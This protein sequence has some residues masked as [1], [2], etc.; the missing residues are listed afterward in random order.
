MSKF[1]WRRFGSLWLT[2]AIVVI[3]VWTFLV[4]D[5]AYEQSEQ[6]TRGEYEAEYHIE[7]AEDRIERICLDL[8]RNDVIGCIHEE[9]QTSHEYAQSK[10]D[11]R[12]QQSMAKWAKIMTWVTGLGA[13]VGIGGLFLILQTLW[14]TREVNQIMRDEQRPWVSVEVGGVEPSMFFDSPNDDDGSQSVLALKGIVT[15]SNSG[16]IPARNVK[17]FGGF[18][19]GEDPSDMNAAVDRWREM[20]TSGWLA[21]APSGETITEDHTLNSGLDI[22]KVNPIGGVCA[23]RIRAVILVMYPDGDA[24]RETLFETSLYTVLPKGGPLASIEINGIRAASTIGDCG[25]YSDIKIGQR[26]TKVTM[27]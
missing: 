11:L 18:F 22:P 27:T 24:I 4:W 9:Y 20:D 6:A 14:A 25:D 16:K 26:F 10:A 1:D 5:L 12:A 2:W 19:V 17:C 15:L 13:A 23:P 8:A 21:I 3:G 7:Y